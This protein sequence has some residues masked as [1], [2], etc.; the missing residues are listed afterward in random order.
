[1]NWPPD[2]PAVTKWLRR[3]DVMRALNTFA[4]GKQWEECGYRVHNSFT[5][6]NSTASVFLLPDIL[7]EIPV[8]LF[9][10]D[11]DYI[12][13]HLGNE[14]LIR[15]LQWNGQ[16]GFSKDNTASKWLFNGEEIG[17]VT[18][19]R[20]L[21]Y[22]RIYDSSHMV[23]FE[24]PLRARVL[25]NVFAGLSDW[26][27]SGDVIH[28]SSDLRFGNGTDLPH[29]DNDEQQRKLTEATWRA[30][31]RA[32]TTALIVILLGLAGFFGY[33]EWTRRRAQ[34]HRGVHFENLPGS[35][36]SLLHSFLDAVTRWKPR[37]R[38]KN[39]NYVNLQEFRQGPR[40]VIDDADE[41]DELPDRV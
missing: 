29:E 4:P 2:L 13:N 14:M 36:T 7:E 24:H 19:E 34:L 15:S 30:Y 8:M 3:E 26:D 20:N 28:Y 22:V 9:N 16:Q 41:V 21:T 27:A 40:I 33:W 5:A 31:Y 18:E 39:G 11:K 17:E 6:Q 1:M 10:G 25:V 37:R 32:G 38:Q 23:A 12:C 35:S